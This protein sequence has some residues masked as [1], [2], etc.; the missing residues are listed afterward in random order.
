MTTKLPKQRL[1]DRET[2][3]GRQAKGVGERFAVMAWFAELVHTSGMGIWSLA[4][5]YAPTKGRGR[6]SNLMYKYRNGTVFPSALI[7]RV[8]RDYDVLVNGG[9]A[10]W[11]YLDHRHYSIQELCIPHGHFSNEV[12][13]VVFGDYWEEGLAFI[14][15]RTPDEWYALFDKMKLRNDF[16][17]LIG[18]VVLLRQC[19]SIYLEAAGYQY[20][21]FV[22]LDLWRACYFHQ[23][24]YEFA[25]NLYEWLEYIFCPATVITDQ[26]GQYS[27]ASKLR[28]ERYKQA[29]LEKP[30]WKIERSRIAIPW[31][32]EI[33]HPPTKDKESDTN[34][35]EP[36][37]EK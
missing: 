8:A 14:S 2:K 4:E 24:Y 17:G 32:D 6:S 35:L 13:Q 10:L 11:G 7:L 18:V 36:D 5:R 20:G 29:A 16:D 27:S 33:L 28:E 22:L 15:S 34:W 30:N 1:M 12:A 3:R 21:C 9:S 25:D 31:L 37:K 26:S 19:K 23:I